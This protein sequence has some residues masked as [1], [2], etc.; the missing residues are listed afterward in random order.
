MSEVR[1]DAELIEG[2]LPQLMRSMALPDRDDPLHQLPLA[3]LRVMR[4]LAG[5]VR[6]PSELAHDLSI[7]LSSVTQ[8]SGRLTEAGLVESVVDD[9]DRRVRNLAL[10]C[11]GE[12]LFAERRQSRVDRMASVLEQLSE[13]ER[14]DILAALRRLSQVSEIAPHDGESLELVDELERAK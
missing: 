4:A 1:R 5:G 3:Q 6:T 2:L 14:K 9:D 11:E 8:L 13:Q 10:S 12:R 7:S